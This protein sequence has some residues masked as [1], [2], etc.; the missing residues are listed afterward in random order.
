MAVVFGDLR[1]AVR[2][3]WRGRFVTALTVLT[4]SLGIGVVTALFAVVNGVLLRPI[5]AEQDRVVHISKRDTQRGGFALALSLPEFAAWRDESRSFEM[6]AA[7]DHAASGPVAIDSGG[8]RP[9]PARLAPVSADF[10][11]V[12][13]RGEPL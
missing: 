1:Y 9:S 13:Q 7:V 8:G 5:V 10:F 11:R 6:L 12:V 2:I 4:L 3:L